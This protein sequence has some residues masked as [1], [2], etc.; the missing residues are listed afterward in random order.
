MGDKPEI[1]LRKADVDFTFSMN[2]KQWDA[3][4]SRMPVPSGW[5]VRMWEHPSGTQLI[6]VNVDSTVSLSLQPLFGD[7]NKPPFM[8]IVENYF[9][10][11]TLPAITDKLRREIEMAAQ[12]E[13]SNAYSVKLTHQVQG[14]LEVLEFRIT[15][16]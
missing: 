5:T 9:K 4:A 8:L 6:A 13:V 3:A 16:N 1:L 11:G 15:E 7:D 14:S 2:K 10:A 12:Q